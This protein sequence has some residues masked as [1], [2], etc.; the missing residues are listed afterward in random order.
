MTGGVDRYGRSVDTSDPVL[1]SNVYTV[2]T[3]PH[4]YG[5]GVIRRSISFS[6]PLR[7]LGVD[8]CGRV[9]DR[10]GDCIYPSTPVWTL[11]GEE[12]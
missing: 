7:V 9:D 6:S 8:R 12:G 2:H 10:D 4:L 1:D 11:E 5:G 3:C